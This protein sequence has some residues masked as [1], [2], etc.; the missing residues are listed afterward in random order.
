MTKYSATPPAWADRLLAWFCPSYLLE[1]LMGDLHEQFADQVD[2]VGAKK[3][4]Q[5]YVLEVIRFIR[6]YFLK[7]RI[8]S[9]TAA[10]THHRKPST[11]TQ[12]SFL[13]P[14]MIRS[15]LKIALRTLWRSKGYA[16]INV[17]GLAVAF[18]IIGRATVRQSFARERLRTLD[19]DRFVQRDKRLQR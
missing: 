10:N 4:R 14:A 1:E 3:A 9:R 7:R 15:Y 17:V 13:Q 5:F 16:A 2:Q 18:C 19:E 8:T 12:P 11:Y 6:P